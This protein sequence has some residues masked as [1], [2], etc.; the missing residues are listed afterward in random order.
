MDRHGLIADDHEFC[1]QFLE[2]EP[3]FEQVVQLLSEHGMLAGGRL[4]GLR[5]PGVSPKV[6]FKL[7]EAAVTEHLTGLEERAYF[8]D[9]TVCRLADAIRRTLRLR[10][11][12][13]R[14][15]TLR[16]VLEQAGLPA[17][18]ELRIAAAPRPGKVNICLRVSTASRE[19]II[20]YHDPLGTCFFQKHPPALCTYLYC[21]V[22]Q[23]VARLLGPESVVGTL[24]PSLEQARAA[25]RR[26]GPAAEDMECLLPA[27]L[28]QPDR[29]HA[30]F[31]LA[32][33]AREELTFVE[34][35]RL[36]ARP[37]A[38]LHARSLGICAS[39]NGVSASHPA[40]DPDL[41]AALRENA[42]HIRLR[43]AY[44]WRTWIRERNWVTL[45]L[46]PL[47]AG[48]VEAGGLNPAARRIP[49]QLLAGTTEL[50]REWDALCAASIAAIAGAG[51]LG[52][53]DY[54][55]HNLFVSRTASYECRLFDF[56]HL[57]FVDPAY[58]SGHS[59]F[60]LV[61]HAVLEAGIDDA[62]AL[63]GIVETYF[64]AYRGAFAAELTD[65][66][67][68]CWAGGEADRDER[69]ARKFAGFT[70]LAVFASEWRQYGLA[71]DRLAPVGRLCR[72]LIA[73]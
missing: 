30:Y 21:L 52:H 38:R 43:D 63:R 33:Y 59:V 4:A 3:P 42:R 70:V 28:V 72:E 31:L 45:L 62:T 47:L 7:L 27:I 65:S 60:S 51:V 49:R 14:E 71:S 58:E 64:D 37:L 22:E 68:R 24:S 54:K 40:P 17:G 16:H 73:A 50:R 20:R 32:D 9:V 18:P 2:D 15:E 48:G 66:R 12:L 8:Q 6:R 11:L 13:H 35:T 34:A 1:R 69:R 41:L 57:T 36:F 44:G 26:S 29:S 39:Y 56:D 55:L 61:K 5:S 25:L 67:R 10:A 19:Y 23:V 46:A 53:L